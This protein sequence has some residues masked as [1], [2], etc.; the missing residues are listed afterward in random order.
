[1]DRA[2]C[3]LFEDAIADRWER[4]DLLARVEW[5][6]RTHSQEL[7]ELGTRFRGLGRGRARVHNRLR[8]TE[9]AMEITRDTVQAHGRRIASLESMLE[10]QLRINRENSRCLEQF[11]A[12]QAELVARMERLRLER[13]RD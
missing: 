5:L 8:G 3:V 10:A 9:R 4:A 12:T 7:W 1:M 13:T 11:E 2:A 6:G